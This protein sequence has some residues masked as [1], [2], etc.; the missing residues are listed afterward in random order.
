MSDQRFTH[1]EL[2]DILGVKPGTIRGEATQCRNKGKQ[3]RGYFP[4]G[5]KWFEIEPTEAKSPVLL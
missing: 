1:N 2:A 3:Y 4:D 5:A